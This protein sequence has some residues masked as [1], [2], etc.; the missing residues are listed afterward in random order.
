MNQFFEIFKDFENMNKGNHKVSKHAK[1]WINNAFNECKNLWGFNIEKSIVN[2]FDNVNV[3][4]ELVEMLALFI[5]QV[6]KKDGSLYL[7]MRIKN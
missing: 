3:I 6:A 7:T 5:L 4:K 1:M 2:L